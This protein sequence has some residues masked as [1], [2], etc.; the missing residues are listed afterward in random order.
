MVL[1]STDRRGG[2]S[3]PFEANHTS[4]MNA[5]PRSLVPYVMSAGGGSD[6]RWGP[7]AVAAVWGDSGGD[8]AGVELVVGVAAPVME[9]IAQE[10]GK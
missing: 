5:W 8:E 10:V 1:S 4:T 3:S 2:N 7:G 9:R 6:G